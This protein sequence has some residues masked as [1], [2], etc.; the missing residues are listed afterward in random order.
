LYVL[1]RQVFDM[2]GKSKYWTTMNSPV[3]ELFI[4]GRGGKV[5]DVLFGRPERGFPGP[6]WER[7]ERRLGEVRR[8]LAEYFRGGR[9][10]FDLELA[11]EGTP[12]QLAAWRQLRMIPYGSTISYG[13]QARRMGKPGA[14]RAVGAANGRNPISIIVPCHRVIGAD[15]RL[16]GF[17][18]G[19]EIKGR[20]LELENASGFRR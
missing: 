6:E 2:S 5:T 7:S 16:T 14:A 12:F 9:R 13:E 3:G 17:G 1:R 4:A 18:G 11:P 19:L 8:Q 20:L 10:V 15:G